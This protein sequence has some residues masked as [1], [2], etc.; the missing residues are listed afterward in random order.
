LIGT[1]SDMTPR[2]EGVIHVVEPQPH[3][4]RRERGCGCGG[5]EYEK[6]SKKWVEYK[7]AESWDE[8][9]HILTIAAL[10]FFPR[11]CWL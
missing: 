9:I 1:T 8:E 3:D 4:Q 6:A 7:R 5:G 10:A 2:S 11:V